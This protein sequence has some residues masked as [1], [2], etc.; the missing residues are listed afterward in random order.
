MGGGVWGGVKSFRSKP[1]L[2]GGILLTHSCW[3][4]GNA[5]DAKFS[6]GGSNPGQLPF[7]GGGGG[8]VKF[9]LP[10]FEPPTMQARVG[11]TTIQPLLH[12]S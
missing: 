2:W 4:N 11:C 8:G 5:A 6:V 10:G 3:S 9:K 12:L 7:G 1:K